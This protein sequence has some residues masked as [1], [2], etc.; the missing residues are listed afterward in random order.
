MQ[1]FRYPIALPKLRIFYFAIGVAIS[2]LLNIASPAN[3]ADITFNFS[4]SVT[5]TTPF[6]AD[7]SPGNDSSPTNNII[8]TLDEIIY[9][10]EYAVNN[11]DAEN[12]V[13]TANISSDQE[14]TELPAVCKPP[15]AIVIEPDDSQTVDCYLGDIASGS[16]GFIEI[17]AR[18]IGQR[19]DSTYVANN[20]I[21]AATGEFSS[22]T[23]A[24]VTAPVVETIVSASPQAD[25]RKNRS[26]RQLGVRQAPDGTD[27]VVVRYPLTMLAGPNG[28]GSEPLVGDIV[29]TD[30]LFGDFL[31]DPNGKDGVAESP[32]PGARLYD[33]GGNHR[34]C[35]WNS[36][37]GQNNIGEWFL[38]HGNLSVAGANPERAVADSGDWSCSQANPGDPITI[39]I[40][41]ADTTGNHVPSQ[42]RSGGSLPANESYLISGTI[43]IWIPTSEILDNG[44]DLKL[45]NQYSR[46]TN[47][48]VSGQTNNDPSTPSTNNDPDNNTRTFTLIAAGGSFN[49]YYS[50]S[51][52]ARGSIL[53]PMTNRNS[54]DG[55]VMPGQNFAK[56]LYG[57]NN[58]ILDWE[59]YRYC[60]KFDSNTLQLTPIP[61]DS[62][63]AVR[64][65]NG[66]PAY[67]YKIEYGTGDENGNAG[68][69]S[70]YDAMRTATCNDAESADGWYTDMTAVPGGVDVITKIRFIALEDFPAGSTMDLAVN[71]I[72]RNFYPGT[73]TKIPTGALMPNFSAVSTP[74]LPWTVSNANAR[75]GWYHGTYVP[76]N[77][78]GSKAWGDRLFLSRGIV[79]VT[80]ETMPDDTVNSMV[81]GDTVGF[82][83][84]PSVT[85]IVDPAPVNPEVLVRDILPI[86]FTYVPGS[87]NI[88]PDTV[89]VNPDGTTILQWDFGPSV[90]NQP[91]PE[92]IFDAQ[93]KFDVPNN[94][95]ALNTVVIESPDDATPESARTAVRGVTI[96]NA[97]A[98][99]IVKE[100]PHQLI[101]QD[102]GFTYELKYANTGTVD[103]GTG[104]FIDILPY[105]GDG[106][107]PA[108]NYSGSL[109][110]FSITGTNGETF[111]YTNA[112]P[113]SISFDPEDATNQPGGATQWCTLPQLGTAGCPTTVADVTATRIATPAFLK[114]TP[115][116]TLVITMDTDG[117]QSGDVYTNVW[118]GRVEDL[119]G[120][121]ES[122]A[123]PVSVRVPS[124][125]VLVKRITAING[126][127]LTNIVD[128]PNDVNDN[129]DNWPDDYLKGEID[130]GTIVSGDTLEYTIYY[131]SNGGTDVRGIGF[132]DLVPQYTTFVNNSFNANTGSIDGIGTTDLG[133]E[134][135]TAL[136]SIF[137]TS[138]NDGDSGTF[139]NPGEAPSVTCS[140]VNDNGAV[141][142]DVGDVSHVGPGG[143]TSA[144][145]GYIRFRAK[146]N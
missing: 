4:T 108:T 24:S 116:R 145:Y 146:V 46:V 96:G 134:L 66:G 20:D 31:S 67:D 114:N 103:V 54:G 44:G 126:E 109:E 30:T 88:I 42:H 132:C 128:D 5:G 57:H 15:S 14:W 125:L 71:F 41:G 63:T 97:A 144:A 130:G 40:T 75:N 3:A 65:F 117:N 18:V 2:L 55:V 140:A 90:P 82:R 81:A 105:I 84:Q 106:R 100:V 110:F 133:I 17:S 113:A 22:D 56:R 59:D 143:T 72:A 141:V 131:L 23:S 115:T 122:N 139:Y 48:S 99:G 52:T 39:T 37:P 95:Q 45:T 64:V 136:G 1:R 89:V 10:W 102:E 27:G 58:A 85:A 61:G 50:R 87:A 16:N 94:T 86:E 60:E 36:E 35:A 11:G 19:P 98:F 142:V 101:E 70:S 38:P 12:V 127:L 92:I 43:E 26:S 69:Y 32:V 53:F 8:R 107:T 138:A 29:I 124:N 21:V 91:L 80:K 6:S 9:K 93:A 118:G 112:T 120:L 123:V 77:H 51:I 111:R 78:T 104:D 74:T 68:T 129:D 137:F 83:L 79:R 25:L 49:Q 47:Q 119:L 13:L 135:S 121:L 62:T 28:K 76:S 7:D 73:T 34:G 33:W